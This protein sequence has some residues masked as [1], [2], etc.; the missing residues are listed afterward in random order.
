[1]SRFAP[2]AKT[3]SASSPQRTEDAQTLHSHAPADSVR[4]PS[5]SPWMALP[6]LSVS[7][8]VVSFHEVNRSARAAGSGPGGLARGLRCRGR[9]APRISRMRAAARTLVLPDP[10]TPEISVIGALAVMRSSSRDSASS[11]VRETDWRLSSDSAATAAARAT[12]S[13]PGWITGGNY[14]SIRATLGL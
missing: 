7:I 4:T 13:A 8:A 10:P 9:E 5:R 2:P 3:L 14:A 6:V 1:M 12:F 11:A